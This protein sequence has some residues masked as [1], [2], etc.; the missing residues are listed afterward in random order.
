VAEENALE[1]PVSIEEC[2]RVLH[3]NPKL[4]ELTDD[5]LEALTPLIHLSEFPAGATLFNEGDVSNNFS[6][7]ASGT[8]EVYKTGSTGKKLTLNILH[9][10]DL[11]G[12]MGLLN[13]TQRSA[14][15]RALTS[16]RLLCFHS[17]RFNEALYSGSLPA[18]RMVLAFARILAQRLTATDMDLFNL[19]EADP[20]NPRFRGL[21]QFDL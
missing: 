9:D 3:A 18:H 16:V 15:A 4:A 8:V 6:V 13:D 7:I 20:D 14:T 5:D 21:K 11:L 1:Q 10:S 2:R 12:E 17:T 19:F